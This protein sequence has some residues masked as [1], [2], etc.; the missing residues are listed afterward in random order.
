MI[1]RVSISNTGAQS[2]GSSGNFGLSIS[3]NGQV[4]AFSSDATNLPPDTNA[5]RDTNNKT[6]IFVRDI[7]NGTTSR[8]SMTVDGIQVLLSSFNPDISDDGRFVAF[9]SEAIMTRFDHTG[10]DIFIADRS[11]GGKLGRAG[12]T[13]DLDAGSSFNG[14]LS[15]EGEN[16]AFLSSAAN[17]LGIGNDRNF[18]W[19]VFWLDRDD[20]KF[21]RATSQDN[22]TEAN[23]SNHSPPAISSD[24]RYVAFYSDAT[25]LIAGGNTAG[26]FLAD[27]ATHTLRKISG[28]LH[29]DFVTR[30]LSPA[31]VGLS[32]LPQRARAGFSFMT[33]I[34]AR[35]KT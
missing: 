19:D 30:P 22:G 7:A 27:I 11:P 2:N 14:V 20:D 32:H 13:Q 3:G 15:A 21:R 28:T 12:S 10:S 5:T 9:D 1:R 31:G 8:V 35:W 4:V 34:P 33:A 16:V 18:K 25:N 23:S 26:V 24:G 6:D 29:P 17:L